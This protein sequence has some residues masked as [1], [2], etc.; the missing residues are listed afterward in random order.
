MKIIIDVNFTPY[1]KHKLNDLL[2][3]LLR[4]IASLIQKQNFPDNLPHPIS[5][6]I[7]PVGSDIPYGKFELKP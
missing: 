3:S 5:W 2:A 7:A 6:T 1:P 4:E